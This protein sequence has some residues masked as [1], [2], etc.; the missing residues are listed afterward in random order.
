MTSEF[1]QCRE[2]DPENIK[3]INDMLMSTR[4]PESCV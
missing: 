3:G 1:K 4:V 2:G